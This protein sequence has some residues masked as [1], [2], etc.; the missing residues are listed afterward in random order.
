MAVVTAATPL[1][2]AAI[3]TLVVLAAT[4]VVAVLLMARSDRQA[5]ARYRARRAVTRRTP[6]ETNGTTDTDLY[7]QRVEEP[8]GRWSP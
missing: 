6:I 4:I 5:L 8:S 1:L 7:W 3:G 2:A